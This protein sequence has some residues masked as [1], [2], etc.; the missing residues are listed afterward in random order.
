MTRQKPSATLS[1]GR[2]GMLANTTQVSTGARKGT[3]N[4][5]NSRGDER[6]RHAKGKAKH[7]LRVRG[8]H[9]Q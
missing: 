5:I 1:G 6:E 2:T 3:V 7:R 9:C 8:I 4:F